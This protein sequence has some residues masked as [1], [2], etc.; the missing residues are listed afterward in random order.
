MMATHRRHFLRQAAMGSALVGLG[1]F[2]F[3]GALRPVSADE[4]KLD[5]RKVQFSADIEPLVRLLEE[6][7]RA[8]VIEVFAD[9]VRRGTSYQ[10]ILAALLLAGVRNVQP[11]PSVGFKFHAVL[12]V[13]SAHLASLASPDSDRWLPI[14]W[15]L[16][17]FKSAQASDERE[18]DWTMP[19]VDESR[20][21]PAHRAQQELI[22]ALD[23]WDEAAADVAVTSLA[24]SA[25]AGELFEI[26]ARY[27]ARDYR[28]IGH[29]AIFVA[30]GF[31][32]IQCIGWR[33]AEPVLR[34]LAYAI[35]N[36][37][38]EPNPAESDLAPDRPY[39][40]N[41]ERAR[42]IRADWRDGKPDEVATREL[43]A[44]LRRGDGDEACELVVEMLNRGVAPG[45][46]YDALFLG[47]GELLARQPGIVSLH[48]VTTTNAMHYAFQSVANDETR[49][50]LLLQNTAFL[51]LF[52]QSMRSRGP[53][54]DVALDTWKAPQEL[55][56]A[57]PADLFQLV[58][59]RNQDAAQAMLAYLE[60]GG[61]PQLLLHAAR[62][63]VFVKGNDSHDY[64]FSSA[65]FEDYYAV[66][67]TWRNQF[68]A[69]GV[70]RLRGA[71]EPDNSLV[72]RT[73]AAL[74]S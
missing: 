1:D 35:L 58:G 72:A 74:Q 26:F 45:S 63:L 66:S 29:K 23:R 11:R 41:L 61:D 28:N 73:R 69:A 65:I 24:R 48:A 57:T 19:P 12:V 21:P 7:P 32:T 4:A 30:N 42:R 13:N 8:R 27:G 6:T 39:R 5:P 54:A 40:K 9:Q 70:Y 47:S 14:F 52:L 10:Q 64:K 49:R 71:G 36:H 43:L 44:T 31:R 46:I 56:P 53:V 67:P 17:Y 22:G 38:N 62:R 37:T 20:V 25:G 33:Y 68:L 51:P 34:S 50:L 15:A 55:A 2:G 3:L 60:R 59:P 16:D 18:G